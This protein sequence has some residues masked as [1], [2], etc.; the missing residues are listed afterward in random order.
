MRCGHGRYRYHRGCAAPQHSYLGG[1]PRHHGQQNGQ[2][3]KET[4]MTAFTA[5]RRTLAKHAEYLRVK[6]EIE[7]L[8]VEL[9]VE[10]L[11]IYPGDAS[12][13]ARKAVYG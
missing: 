13:I 10:D 12:K 4:A 2:R 7:A 1:E 6:R 5:L 11:G 8:P 3:K 9:A